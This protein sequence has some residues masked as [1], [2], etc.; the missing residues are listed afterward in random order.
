E[1]LISMIEDKI[2][3]TTGEVWEAWVDLNYR[4]GKDPSVHGAAEH[5]LAVVRKPRAQKPAARKAA[6]HKTAAR[7]PAKRK[8]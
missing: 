4:L 6:P 5:L 2:N 1:G 3:E 8:K 7:K